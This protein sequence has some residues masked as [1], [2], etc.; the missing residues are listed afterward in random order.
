MEKGGLGF[1][2]VLAEYQERGGVGRAVSP[3]ASTRVDL[4][5]GAAVDGRRV[6]FPRRENLSEHRDLVE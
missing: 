6:G 3:R 1:L 4:L 2:R 5:S